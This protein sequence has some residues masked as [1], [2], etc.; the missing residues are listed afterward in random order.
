MTPFGYGAAVPVDHRQTHIP[1][2]I[3]QLKSAFKR[4]N[5]ITSSQSFVE[6]PS[7]SSFTTANSMSS[8]IDGGT[9]IAKKSSSGDSTTYSIFRVSSRESI[10]LFELIFALGN[11]EEMGLTR[12]NR[13]EGYCQFLRGLVAHRICHLH[14][15][16]NKLCRKLL[17]GST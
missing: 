15:F 17:R 2:S 1:S 10:K 4:S 9:A 11:K 7:N 13:N 3:S 14:T 5:N 8:T 16:F 12:K 6:D